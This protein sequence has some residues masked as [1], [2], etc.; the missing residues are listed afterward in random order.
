MNKDSLL[1]HIKQ[2]WHESQIPLVFL[3]KSVSVAWQQFSVEL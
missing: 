3:M 2:S 1:K